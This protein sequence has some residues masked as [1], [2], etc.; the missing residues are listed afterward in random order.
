M[1]KAF[2][3][4]LGLILLLALSSSSIDPAN[5]MVGRWQQRI[6]GATLLFNF[7]SDGSYDYFVNGKSYTSGHYFVRQDTTGIADSRCN[8]NYFGTYKIDFYA[9]DSVRFS[10]IQDTCQDRRQAAVRLALGRIR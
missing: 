3:V 9:P 10:A 1:K 6:K 5:P 7:R 2:I 8:A 4:P